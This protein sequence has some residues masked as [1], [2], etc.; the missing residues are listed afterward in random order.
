MSWN[1]IPGLSPDSLRNLQEAAGITQFPSD[2][3]SWYQVINGLYIQ[4]GKVTIGAGA[5]IVV[6]FKI[7]LPVQVLG[8]FTQGLIAG[9]GNGYVN[10]DPAGSDLTQFTAVNTGAAKD[11]YWWAIGV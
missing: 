3:T 4:G 11:F 1:S 7:P 5:T 10:I 8:V 9:A 2:G 6:P